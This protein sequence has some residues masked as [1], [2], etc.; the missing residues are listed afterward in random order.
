MFV[1]TFVSDIK[2][3]L[4]L[5]EPEQQDTQ[6]PLA[7]S[8]LAAFLK[9]NNYFRLG[10]RAALNCQRYGPLSAREVQGVRLSPDY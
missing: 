7:F 10:S 9:L 3:K 6:M 5:T 8:P 1:E 4:I 2:L